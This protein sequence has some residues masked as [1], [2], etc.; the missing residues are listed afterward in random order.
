YDGNGTYR[1]RFMP[2][3][4]GEWSFLTRSRTASLDG[5][6]GALTATVPSA[7]NHGPVRVRNKF[8]FA[9]RAA[10]A[11]RHSRSFRMT[12]TGCRRHRR[13]GIC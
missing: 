12:G 9:C 3:I 2:D 4:E 10:G 6:T 8:H 1:I 13:S 11:S 7:G 5:K